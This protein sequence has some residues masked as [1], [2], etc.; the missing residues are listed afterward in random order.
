MESINK[1]LG[2]PKNENEGKKAISSIEIDGIKLETEKYYFEYPKDIQEK[3]GILGYNRTMIKKEDIESKGISIMNLDK[4]LSNGEFPDH[5]L[6]HT[7]RNYEE[8]F[9]KNKLFI[10]KLFDINLSEKVKLDFRQSS[11]DTYSPIIASLYNKKDDSLIERIQMVQIYKYQK[12]IENNEVYIVGEDAFNTN[13]GEFW[14]GGGDVRFGFSYED[15]FFIKYMAET[16][17]NFLD[18]KDETALVDLRGIREFNKFILSGNKNLLAKIK[19]F[20]DDYNV[21]TVFSSIKIEEYDIN[22]IKNRIDEINNTFSEIK[23]N[24]LQGRNEEKIILNKLNK[25]NPNNYEDWIVI[26]DYIKIFNFQRNGHLFDVENGKA[27]RMYWFMCTILGVG[28]D[29][30]REVKIPIFINHAIIPQLSWGHAKY[31]N[32]VNKKGFNFFEFKH[33]N[34]LPTKNKK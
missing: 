5:T 2:I 12:Q 7:I 4:A 21:N 11:A 31:T 26:E 23:K 25:S 20:L 22:E 15:K 27:G 8:H 34:H 28:L 9:V 18:G 24:L 19:K 13:Q 3:T 17:K 16:Y 29:S 33:A 32:F 1:N 14:I 6:N 10:Q 30:Y